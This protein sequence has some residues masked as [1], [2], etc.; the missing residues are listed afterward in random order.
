MGPAGKKASDRTL[1][2][3]LGKSESPSEFPVDSPNRYEVHVPTH[4]YSCPSRPLNCAHQQPGEQFAGYLIGHPKRKFVTPPRTHAVE[5]QYRRVRFAEF[6]LESTDPL[7]Q[8]SA[9]FVHDIPLPRF[10]ES[11]AHAFR[12]VT[13]RDAG[14]PEQLELVQYVLQVT[15][16]VGLLAKNE[17]ER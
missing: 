12:Q 13:G 8:L 7:D 6:A 4:F 14:G 10:R 11:F 17:L 1:A 15:T 9:E 2:D 16:E 3:L 5:I